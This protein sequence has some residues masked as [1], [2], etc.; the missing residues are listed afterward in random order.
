MIEVVEIDSFEQLSEYSQ[1]WN[2]LLQNSDT[3][4]VFLT[5]EYCRSWWEIFGQDQELLVLLAR[6]DSEIIGIAPLTIT[7]TRGLGR[8][9]S[10]VEFL[11]TVQSDYMDFIVGSDKEVVLD[12]FYGY[13]WSI[14]DRWDVIRLRQIPEDSSTIRLSR[15]HLGTSKRPFCFRQGS[16]CMAVLIRGHKEEIQKRINQQKTLRNCINRLKRMGEIEYGYAKDTQECLS[17]MDSFFQLHINRWKSTLTLSTFY[18]ERERQFYR[19]LVQALSNKGCLHFAYLNLNGVPIALIVGFEYN[20]SLSVHRTVYDRLYY[21]YSPGR[22]I[23]RYA[24]QY[25]LDNGLRDLD[26]LAGIEEYKGYI[27]NEVRDTKEIHV[28][29]SSVQKFRGQLKYAARKSRVFTLLFGDGW[30]WR[31]RMR[32]RKYRGRYGTLG[33]AKKIIH[34]VTSRIIDFSS[35]QIFECSPS[36][37]VEL[38][39]KCPLDIRVG[40]EADLNSIASF[41]GYSEKSPQISKLEKRFS[42]GDIP[43]LAFSGKTLAHV[44]WLCRRSEVEMEEI[45]ASLAFRDNEAYIMDCNTFFTFRGKNIYPVVLQRILK[46]LAAEKVGKVYIGCRTSNKASLKGIRKAGFS[47]VK[48]IRAVRLFGRKIGPGTIPAEP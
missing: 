23:V 35:N 17:Y 43:Y 33:L 36:C 34:R 25:C 20:G 1:Q 27:T 21:K 5:Y 16:G 12:A 2:E 42:Y 9:V 6:K 45:W 28:Y 7:T 22:I 40:S 11:G 37:P 18:N 41:H 44:S 32:L 3:N 4:V 15:E 47:F 8:T 39:A 46:D 14:R 31:L 30:P 38:A 24:V 13:L 29:K 48:T 19:R 10:V 26:L